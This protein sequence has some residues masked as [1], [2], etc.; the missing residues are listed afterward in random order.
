MGVGSCNNKIIKI[1]KIIRLKSPGKKSCKEEVE[2]LNSYRRKSGRKV[3]PYCETKG[4]AGDEIK[5]NCNATRCRPWR[6]YI[7]DVAQRLL[8]KKRF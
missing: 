3:L 1:R 2:K 5:Q 7:C 8:F 4:L 6:P